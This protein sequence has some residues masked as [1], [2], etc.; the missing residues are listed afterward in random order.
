MHQC[1]YVAFQ[2]FG[3]RNNYKINPNQELVAIGVTNTIGS[4]FSAYPVTGSFSRTA[5]N[6]KSGVRTPLAGIKSAI[7]IIV[8]LY[9][10]TPAFYW[11]PT[12]GLSAI[13]IHAVADLVA[14]PAQVYSFWRVSPLEFVIWWAAVLVIVFSTIEYG[15]YTALC[16]SAALLLFRIVFP[17]GRFLGKVTLYPDSSNT[18]TSR[19]V[20]VPLLAGGVRNPHVKVVPP[21]PGVI[22]YRLEESFVYPNC[23]RMNNEIVDYVKAN[24]QRGQDYTY[25]KD[26]DRPWNDP[27]FRHNVVESDNQSKPDLHAIV[28]D[29]SAVFVN[30]PLLVH[31][32]QM[33][34]S[35][36]IDT[37]AVQSLIDA[38]SQ[39]E[40]W[41]EHSVEVSVI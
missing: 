2:A 5:I 21:P 41:V 14:S 26:G 32:A 24:M 16:A 8:A 23:S 34:Y 20:Y 28:L 11:I 33:F 22:I 15:I 19:E 39:V 29:F 35:S 25:V 10:L 17:R 40:K 30:S 36:Q 4:C 9:K 13:I 27:S 1:S 18:G 38:R 12:A 3:R 7:V 31:V 6:S 37:T